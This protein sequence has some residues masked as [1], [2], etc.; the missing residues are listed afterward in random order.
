MNEIQH[1][2][3]RIPLVSLRCFESFA[4]LGEVTAA[5]AEL[6]ITPSAV[7]HQLAALESRLNTPLTE[8]RGRR[9]VLNA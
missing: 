8:R 1:L 5:A 7:S 9:L 2:V 4:R 6:G 3:R